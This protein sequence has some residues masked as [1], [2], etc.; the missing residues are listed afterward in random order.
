MKAISIMIVDCTVRIA[1]GRSARRR[2]KV[3]W[4]NDWTNEMTLTER[5]VRTSFKNWSDRTFN[6]LPLRFICQLASQPASQPHSAA[7]QSAS[8]VAALTMPDFRVN[9]RMIAINQLE[10][11]IGFAA[12]GHIVLTMR[13]SLC[14]SWSAK[15]GFQVWF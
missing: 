1:V 8:H 7:S 5:A 12:P 3:S 15:V 10:R 13:V 4:K 9:T 2:V 14:K 11:P 6:S